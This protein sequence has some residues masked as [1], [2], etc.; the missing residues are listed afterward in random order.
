MVKRFPKRL[1][2]VILTLC[3]ILS[4]V[5]AGIAVTN[6]DVIA[7]FAYDK[8]MDTGMRAI[9]N[10]PVCG[11]CGSAFAITAITIILPEGNDPLRYIFSLSALCKKGLISGQTASSGK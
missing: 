1:L 9:P 3:I 4:A 11:L 2:S 6:A 10:D 8:L 5:S 7:E